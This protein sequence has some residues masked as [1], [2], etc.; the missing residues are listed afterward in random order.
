MGYYALKTSC[1]VKYTRLQKKTTQVA[2]KYKCPP[3]RL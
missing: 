3:P 2:K 1:P